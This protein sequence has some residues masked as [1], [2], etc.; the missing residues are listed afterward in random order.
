[1]MHV[2]KDKA[3]RAAREAVMAHLES[4]GVDT[5]DPGLSVYVRVEVE[6]SQSLSG[7]RQVP[8]LR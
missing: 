2:M 5:S 8:A 6:V 3:T 7:G 1:M 4:M